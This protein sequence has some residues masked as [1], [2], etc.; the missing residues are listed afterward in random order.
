MAVEEALEAGDEQGD[1][2]L[3][4]FDGGAAGGEE[5]VRLLGGDGLE[6]GDE[7]SGAGGE[8][9]VAAGFGFGD[10]VLEAVE[11]EEAA[12]GVDEVAG[13]DDAFAVL[14]EQVGD[15]GGG[16][17]GGVEDGD[18]GGAEGEDV[19]AADGAGDRAGFG[20]DFGGFL[21]VVVEAELGEEAPELGGVFEGGGFA[22]GDNEGP[23]GGRR[24]R[25]VEVRRTCSARPE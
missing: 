25:R 18:F 14:F 16:V 15:G 3:G 8:A 10:L 2:F 5:A 17:A 12:A 20:G 6:A 13:G 21:G 24:S 11:I 22:G 7:L 19:A 4:V 1:L 9:V 23:A